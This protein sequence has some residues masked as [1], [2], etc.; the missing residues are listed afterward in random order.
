MKKN[1]Y[2]CILPALL[3]MQACS[4]D[5]T[6]PFPVT[7]AAKGLYVISE[8]G[9]TP[10][11]AKLGF[12]NLGS[13]SF[14]GDYFV[15]QN[16]TE[17]ALGSIAN[18]AIV[19][20]GKLYIIMNVSSEVLVLNP[21]TGTLIKRISFGTAPN[22]KS[23]RYAVGAR[24][25]VFVTAYD[26]TVTSVDTITLTLGSSITVGQDPEGIAVHGNFLYVANS[27][28]LNYPDVDSTVSVIDLNT[29]T[30]IKKIKVGYNPNKVEVAANGDIYV[31]AYGVGFPTPP[32]PVIPSSVSII[33]STTNLLKTTL[34]TTNYGY[35]HVRISGNIAYFFNNY[36]GAGTAKVY[37]TETNT[38][39][40]SEF[41][42]DGTT[43]TT[44]Y[45]I[46]IDEQNGDVYIMD[47]KDYTSAG[48]VTCFDKEG[49]KKFSFSTTPG[50]NPN[51]VV[52]SR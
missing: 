12:Y 22:L 27:G 4:K 49:K 13:S 24:G 48:S 40:R 37:N 32:A 15:Q 36:G 42:T 11:S 10:N 2:K 8:G 6:N 45:G 1:L 47:A 43:I 3:I 25:K 21:Y 33:N 18:D 14:T 31:S 38:D 44:P 23:P 39:I 5:D 28:G 17:T 16:P 7:P 51:K 9:S 30:E 20:G 50:V 29:N 41:I 52:F 34:S 35:S 19:Y 26:N 46:S